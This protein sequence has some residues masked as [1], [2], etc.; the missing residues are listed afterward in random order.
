M[1]S[2]INLL[3]KLGKKELDTEK[4]SKNKILWI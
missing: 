3:K 4:E 1:K 2:G